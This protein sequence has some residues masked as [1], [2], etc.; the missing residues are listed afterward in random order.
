MFF[1][2][3]TNDNSNYNQR[4]HSLDNAIPATQNVVDLYGQVPPGTAINRLT[5]DDYC[6]EFEIDQN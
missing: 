5:T 4:E 6:G 2:M 3:N 1:E